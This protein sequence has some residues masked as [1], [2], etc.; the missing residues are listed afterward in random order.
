MHAPP[1]ESDLRV[2]WELL[3]SLPQRLRDAQPTFALTG[4][5][6]AAGLFDADG[7]AGLRARGRRPPQRARQGRRLGVRRGPPAAAR[8]DPVP[9]RPA[10]VRA[11]PEGGARRLP[12]RRRRRRAVEP[13][14]RARRGAA[15]SRSAAGRAATASASTRAQTASKPETAGSRSA[16]ER[17]RK[18]ISRCVPSQSGLICEWPQRQSVT[19]LRVSNGCPSERTTGMPPV[20]HSDP[21]SSPSSCRHRDR[22]PGSRARRRRRSGVSAYMYEP[23]GQRS[24]IPMICARTSLSSAPSIISGIRL[25]RPTQNAACMQR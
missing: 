6:H 9:Q 7:D 11:R 23:D 20:T 5:L 18:S 24:I 19:R 21:A 25:S 15:A 2:G 3:G 17:S 14:G 1:V 13:R 8:L 12:D 10:L 22:R 16:S 4:G